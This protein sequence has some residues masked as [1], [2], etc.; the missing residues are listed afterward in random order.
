MRVR[1]E[2]T[3]GPAAGKLFTFEEP[4]IFIFGRGENAHCAIPSDKALSSSH[5]MLQLNPPDCVLIDLGSSNGTIVNNA[6]YGGKTEGVPK[7]FG[8]KKPQPVR[9]RDGD[10]IAAGRSRLRVGITYDLLCDGCGVKFV[11]H[12][13]TELAKMGNAPL[14][15]E[16][17]PQK[18]P[19]AQHGSTR[20]LK[21]SRCGKDVTKEG[22]VRAVTGLVEYICSAC[23]KETVHG[24]ELRAALR[25]LSERTG[26]SRGL[27]LG[28]APAPPLIEGYD[29]QKLLGIGGMGAVYL[30]RCMGSGELVAVKAMLPEVAVKPEAAAHFEREAAM[31]TS[32][33]HPNV[34]SVIEQGCVGAVFYFTME[35]VDG[36]DLD[37]LVTARG[38]HL[39]PDESLSIALQTLDGLACAHER[40][41]VHR[42]VKPSNILLAAGGPPW[43]AKVSDFGL[44]KSFEQAGLSSLT[45]D[46]TVCGSLDFLP[47]EQIIRYR[48]VRPTSDVYAT[49]AVLYYMLTGKPVRKGLEGG[50]VNIPEAV[51]VITEEPVVPIHKRDLS[52]PHSVAAVIDKSISDQES[53]RYRD[54]GSMRRALLRAQGG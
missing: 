12:G 7:G 43:T 29:F 50:A 41:I 17:L 6:Q 16:C 51:R 9:L 14:C 52:I 32:V 30:A 35:Y 8:H 11:V 19:E 22:G 38:G 26:S 4:D 37:S 45:S 34:V 42:D 33:Q 15:D 39:T 40:G 3:K 49:G 2:V 10:R 28:E 54:A 46:G 5:F 25:A 53:Q 13:D 27:D 47:R 20:Y 24:D 1:L 23:R 21:C 48:W 36:T 18:A 31:A 44:A